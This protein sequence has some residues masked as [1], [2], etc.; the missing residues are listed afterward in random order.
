MDWQQPQLIHIIVHLLSL[1]AINLYDQYIHAIQEHI[2]R[3]MQKILIGQVTET[4]YRV[5]VFVI[6]L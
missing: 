3:V 4:Y 1:D 6:V 5:L 2:L